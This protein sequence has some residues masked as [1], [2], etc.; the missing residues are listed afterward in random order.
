MGG[1]TVGASAFARRRKAV[2][3]AA[4]GMFHIALVAH[5]LLRCPVDPTV[6]KNMDYQFIHQTE[7][8]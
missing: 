5:S 6:V 2:N 7:G 4:P 1:H 3:N 8:Q